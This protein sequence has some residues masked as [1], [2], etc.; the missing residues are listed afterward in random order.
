[1]F[2]LPG[3]F[4]GAQVVVRHGG[5]EMVTAQGLWPAISRLLG[6]PANDA[7]EQRLMQTYKQVL[8]SFEDYVRLAQGLPSQSFFTQRTHPQM[9]SMAP[10]QTT[11]SSQP[12]YQPPMQQARYAQPPAPATSQPPEKRKRTSLPTPAVP[13]MQQPQRAL[14]AEL[15]AAITLL[16]SSDWNEMTKAVNTLNRLTLEHDKDMLFETFPTLL[17]A[18]T[19]AMDKALPVARMAFDHQVGAVICMERMNADFGP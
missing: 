3:G 9:T 1:M 14:Q 18:L 2:D 12:H 6:L 11:H 8:Q 19:T 5:Y 15:E 17:G 16:G 4:G 13:V 7:T 10:L